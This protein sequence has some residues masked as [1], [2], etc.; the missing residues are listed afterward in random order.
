[1]SIGGWRF[2]VKQLR[3]PTLFLRQA[4][5]NTFAYAMKL[6]QSRL[7]DDNTRGG[8]IKEIGYNYN[9]SA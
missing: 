6:P 3:C 9:I 1:T 5:G 7:I 2:I 8:F 4:T